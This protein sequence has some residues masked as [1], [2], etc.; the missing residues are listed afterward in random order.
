[1]ILEFGE[2][3]TN[4]G[5]YKCNFYIYIGIRKKYHL[6]RNY[7]NIR[8]TYLLFAY[9]QILIGHL[10]VLDTRFLLII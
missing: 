6:Y 10:F 2:Y 8:K 1:M 5:L 3:L 7:Y 9:I 4:N